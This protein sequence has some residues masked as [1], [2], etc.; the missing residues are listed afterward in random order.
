M[1]RFEAGWTRV[2]ESLAAHRPLWAAQ[3]EIFAQIDR[4]PEVRQFLADA[5]QQG[6]LGLAAVSWLLSNAARA[7][8]AAAV[9]V[10]VAPS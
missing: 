5:Q 9:S 7:A 2:V 3:F 10:A 4:A 6:R 1:E 8:S